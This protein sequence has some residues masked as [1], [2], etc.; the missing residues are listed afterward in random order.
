MLLK[1]SK[2]LTVTVTGRAANLVCWQP[3]FVASFGILTE[4]FFNSVTTTSRD[5]KQPVRT[6]ESLVG[7]YLFS[8]Q[9]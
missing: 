3:G 5:R 2:N 1:G 6:P 7:G 8:H 4:A 9:R